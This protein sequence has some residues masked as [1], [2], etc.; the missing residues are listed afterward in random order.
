MLVFSIA[1]AWFMW[2]SHANPD[3]V[4]SAPPL[5]ELVSCI[6]I[7]LFLATAL[8]YFVLAFSRFFQ[9]GAPLT[10]HWKREVDKLVERTLLQLRQR[11]IR[12][13][14][15]NL[16]HDPEGEDKATK[17]STTALQRRPGLHSKRGKHQKYR[18]L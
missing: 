2:R 4:P 13:S 8:V 18:R 10:G 12:R 15:L 1:I 11:K 6:L 9:H 14:L 3:F 16:K 7:T 5:T 17:V